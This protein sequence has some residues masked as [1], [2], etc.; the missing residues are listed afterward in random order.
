MPEHRVWNVGLGVASLDCFTTLWARHGIDFDFVE[1]WEPTTDP[2]RFFKTVP[3]AWISRE[4]AISREERCQVLVPGTRAN[5]MDQPR[6][7][8]FAAVSPDHRRTARTSDYVLFKF[9]SSWTLTTSKLSRVSSTNSFRLKEQPT[10]H[11]SMRSSGEHHVR[12]P[13]RVSCHLT[14]LLTRTRVI[15]L[16]YHRTVLPTRLCA[17]VY[18]VAEWRDRRVVDPYGVSTWCL[19]LTLRPS[20]L[21]ATGTA[22][23]AYRRVAAGRSLIRLAEAVPS[24]DLGQRE[25][26]FGLHSPLRR[27]GAAAACFRPSGRARAQW[28]LARGR[29]GMSG[30]SRVHTMR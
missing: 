16:L 14:A 18:D 25:S 27:L 15:G 19:S 29:A 26:T 23:R 17:R 6:R 11:S 30:C 13:V 2:Q 22:I 7:A 4:P 28:A 12:T 5:R 20:T 3:A 8:T 24:E 21:A 1:A 10:W 9:N